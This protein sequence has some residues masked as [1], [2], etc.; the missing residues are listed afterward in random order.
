MKT[1]TFSIIYDHLAW[2]SKSKFGN[3]FCLAVLIVMMLAVPS[4]LLAGNSDSQGNPSDQKNFISQYFRA[5]IGVAVP[6]GDFSST[7]QPVTLLNFSGG[8]IINL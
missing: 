1:K 8:I 3:H 4:S 6:K 7:K 5:G 2:Y